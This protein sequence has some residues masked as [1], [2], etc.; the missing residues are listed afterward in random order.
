MK[1]IIGL[2][3]MFLTTAASGQTKLIMA[4]SAAPSVHDWPYLIAE[5]QQL[6]NKN[7]LDVVFTPL[8]KN[9]EVASMVGRGESQFAYQMIV[10]DAMIVDSKNLGI[11]IVRI[12]NGAMLVM[13][14]KSSNLADIKTVAISTKMEPSYL[15]AQA[16]IKSKGFDPSK[17]DYINAVNGSQRLQYV[18]LGRADA[19]IMPL[20]RDMIA[21][22][23]GFHHIGYANDVMP[24]FPFQGVALNRKF[25]QDNPAVANKIV[26]VWDSA[27]TWFK[28]PS[29]RERAAALL[30]KFM[31]I[32][33][34]DALATYD[35][36]IKNNYFST[37]STNVRSRID[38]LR[39]YADY[40]IRNE[41]M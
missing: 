34:D 27:I 7:Q 33:Q 22:Q 19:G 39:E 2:L 3:A 11:D 12:N 18:L 1:Y 15:L 13:F 32:S 36:V 26:A 35:I 40:L 23:K 37:E 8:A 25:A 31:Q 4:N 6:F 10:V 5:D 30:A 20:P 17:F 24:T 28:Q 21:Y 38:S 14:G 16:I 41:Q 9:Q 29:N